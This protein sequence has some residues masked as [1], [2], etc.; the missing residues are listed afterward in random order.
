MACSAQPAHATAQTQIS[1]P[2]LHRPCRQYK[3]NHRNRRRQHGWYGDGAQSP[4]IEELLNLTQCLG[5][6]LPS[7]QGPLVHLCARGDRS[8]ARRSPNPASPRLRNTATSRAP[9]PIAQRQDVHAAWDGDYRAIEQAERNESQ[10]AEVKNPVPESMG[11]G[12]Q[13]QRAFRR[14]E[15][16]I[17][18]VESDR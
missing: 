18:I 7:S 13:C 4:S 17:W 9:E 3:R 1:S 8:P 5:R 15:H 10:R 6:A 16:R 12:D 2:V 14:E 11:D